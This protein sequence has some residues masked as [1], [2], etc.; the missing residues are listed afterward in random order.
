MSEPTDDADPDVDA[1]AFWRHGTLP[2][3]REG[4]PQTDAEAAPTA[5]D[6]LDRPAVT[7][8]GRNLADVLRPAYRSLT[9]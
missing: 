3:R 7:V 5:L 9:Q 4:E 1:A 2:P 8:D 6:R